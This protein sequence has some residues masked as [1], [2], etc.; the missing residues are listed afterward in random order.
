MKDLKNIILVTPDSWVILKIK[1]TKSFY[2]VFATWTGGYLDGDSWKIN[3]GITKVEED[4]T[5]YYFYG[6]SGSCYACKKEKYGVATSYGQGVLDSVLSNAYKVNTQ[7]EVLPE[8]T[9]WAEFLN[10]AEL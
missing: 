4:D 1:N 9:N 8:T 2:K 7:I 3:S 5:H 6:Y 10:N